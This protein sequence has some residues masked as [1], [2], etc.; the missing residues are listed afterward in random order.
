MYEEAKEEILTQ[1]IESLRLEDHDPDDEEG[2][3]SD[4]SG[5]V[6]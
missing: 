2:L 1:V 4:V 3:R 5:Q 6:V